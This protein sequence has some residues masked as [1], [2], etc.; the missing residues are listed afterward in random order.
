MSL[1]LQENILNFNLDEIEYYGS[2]IADLFKKYPSEVILDETLRLLSRDLTYFECTNLCDF[3]YTLVRQNG[4]IPKQLARDMVIPKNVSL[5]QDSLYNAFKE[6][7][8]YDQKSLMLDTLLH[9][10]LVND[11]EKIE[12]LVECIVNTLPIYNKQ[13]F[14]ELRS[15][16]SLDYF[17]SLS[18]VHYTKYIHWA[19]LEIAIE[20]LDAGF[21]DF[22][23]NI[24][25][26][27]ENPILCHRGQ[28]YF[29]LLEIQEQ[30]YEEQRLEYTEDEL[31]VINDD[32]FSFNSFQAMAQSDDYKE[33]AL[34]PEDYRI[35]EKKLWFDRNL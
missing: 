35:I 27:S 2:Y 14:Q 24:I 22:A 26:N 20:S 30:C 28:R 12:L 6:C 25:D 4:Y 5:I 3:I 18:S 33:K 23:R 15:N 1:A 9:I 13:L 16:K 11:E 34:T 21:N 17:F 8:I 7:A 19:L 10:G 32:S 29:K 31:K